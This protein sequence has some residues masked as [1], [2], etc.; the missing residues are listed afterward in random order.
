MEHTGSLCTL[1]AYSLVYHNTI[2]CGKVSENSLSLLSLYPY[3][4]H[5]K[6]VLLYLSL[7]FFPSGSYPRYA[8]FKQ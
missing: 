8:S 5:S 1:W 4:L 2:N 7:F 3:V 6:F